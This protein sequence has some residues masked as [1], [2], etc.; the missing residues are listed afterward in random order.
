MTGINADHGHIGSLQLMP[1][2]GR[3]RT[4]FRVQACSLDGVWAGLRHDRAVA[5]GE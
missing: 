4:R 5:E 2:P 3:C 1:Q